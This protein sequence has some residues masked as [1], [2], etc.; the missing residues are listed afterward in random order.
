MADAGGEQLRVMLPAKALQASMMSVRSPTAS[1]GSAQPL[2]LPSTPCQIGQ[3]PVFTPLDR[4]TTAWRMQVCPGAPRRHE[5]VTP[6]SMS[7]GSTGSSI[8]PVARL[9]LGATP[10]SVG[11]TPCN[12]PSSPW[13][14]QACPG[15]P[16][17]RDGFCLDIASAG[18]PSLARRGL[19]SVTFWPLSCASTPQGARCDADERPLGSFLLQRERSGNRSSASSPANSMLQNESF[20]GT[21][22]CAGGLL[23]GRVTFS[24]NAPF[25]TDM[26][27]IAVAVEH[28]PTEASIRKVLNS[29]KSSPAYSD[30]RAVPT[31]PPATIQSG[32]VETS[33]SQARV[34]GAKCVQDDSFGSSDEEPPLWFREIGA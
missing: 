32:C 10:L 16:L 5:V 3:T 4:A 22:T 18:S 13:R 33:G 23:N 11:A 17:R 8:V 7:S 21:P 1:I 30:G 12:V 14:T 25:C 9:R 20:V 24:A 27:P 34:S 28:S 2:T 19:Q 6:L 26:T 29:S 31:S 15:A